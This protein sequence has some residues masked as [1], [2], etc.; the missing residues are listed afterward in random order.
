[1]LFK[2][3]QGKMSK[4]PHSWLGETAAGNGLCYEGGRGSGLFKMRNEAHRVT[5]QEQAMLLDAAIIAAG[6]LDLFEVGSDAAPSNAAA[7]TLHVQEA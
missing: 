5:W 6:L 3:Q 2:T 4:L 1:V 7:T